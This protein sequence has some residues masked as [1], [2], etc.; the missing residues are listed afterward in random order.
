M[1]QR[2][3]SL[4][5]ETITTDHIVRSQIPAIILGDFNMTLDEDTHFRNLIHN[6][7]WYNLA[8]IGNNEEK[9]K[10]SCHVGS[11]NGSLIDFIL[12]DVTLVDQ[13]RNYQVCKLSNIKDHSLLQ[14]SFNLPHP[15]Q[16]RTSLRTLPET[17]IAHENPIF[18]C[19]Y[20][21][22]GGFSMAMLVS[23]RVI[24]SKYP[25]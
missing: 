4:L 17:N 14:V 21:Q 1:G 6:K 9:Q 24:P 11:N 5:P 22:N 7:T 13:F 8:A 19:K 25:S 3:T 23:G 16:S 10:P 20:H 2:Q 12:T 18:P 15:M